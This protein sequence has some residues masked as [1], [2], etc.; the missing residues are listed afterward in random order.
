MMRILRLGSAA[1]ALSL[2]VS[3]AGWR[4]SEAHAAAPAACGPGVHERYQATGPDG[5]TYETW[6]PPVVTD[7]ATGRACSLGHEHGD[8]PQTSAIHDWALEKL[9]WPALLF[10]FVNHHSAHSGIPHRHEDHV[11]NKVYVANNVRL[12]R[13]D[14]KGFARDAQ[15]RAISCDYLMK[16]HQG[17]HSADALSNSAHE[18]VYAARCTDGTEV[19]VALLTPL[20]KANQYTS[21]CDGS[22]VHTSGSTSPS[23]DTGARRIPT[24]ACVNKTVRVA[25]GQTSDVWGLYEL[26]ET[27]ATITDAEGRS[28][29]RVDPWFGVRNP[30]RIADGAAK[31]ATASLVGTEVQGW[32]WSGMSQPTA[33]EDPASVFNGGQRDFYVRETL[34]DNAGGSSIVYTDAYG[35]NATSAPVDHGIRQYI[36]SRSNADLPELERRVFG[37]SDDHAPPGSGV[38]A[39]N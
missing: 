10:G 7:P 1:V 33:Q 35:R 8:D 32:P 39:P 27:V 19:A 21:N 37:L 13:A 14:R 2:V 16:F 28:L 15:G 29:V 3:V 31:V 11:G 9:G 26:W 23:A 4:T 20:G 22:T 38:H 36:G 17:S 18:L 5:Y 30:S 25:P 24:V 6:H 34:V 12:V